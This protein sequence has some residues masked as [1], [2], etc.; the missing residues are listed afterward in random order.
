MPTPFRDQEQQHNDH[1]GKRDQREE[2]AGDDCSFRIHSRSSILLGAVQRDVLRQVVERCL[3]ATRPVGN[4][5][6][7]QAHFD[8]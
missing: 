5:G 6:K 8:A 3:H 2:G 7:R 4:V 1:A